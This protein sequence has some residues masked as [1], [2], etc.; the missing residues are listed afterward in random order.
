MKVAG[1][2]TVH[3][4]GQI[5]YGSVEFARLRGGTGARILKF[6]IAA[7]HDPD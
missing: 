6:S 5:R 4:E 7:F 3:L 2:R 1:S